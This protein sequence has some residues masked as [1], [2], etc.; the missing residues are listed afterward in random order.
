MMLVDQICA[1]S[2]GPCTYTG[3][4]MKSTHRHEHRRFG[5]LSAFGVSGLVGAAFR[6]KLVPETWPSGLRLQS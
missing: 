1:G 6:I 4:D 2:G 3:R 5:L